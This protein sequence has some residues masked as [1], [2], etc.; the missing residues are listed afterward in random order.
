MT[1]TSIT[2]LT[3]FPAFPDLTTGKKNQNS[4]SESG[5]IKLLL[6]ERAVLHPSSQEVSHVPWEPQHTLLMEPQCVAF[7]H[8]C[9]VSEPSQSRGGCC[10]V[11]THAA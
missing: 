2:L 10:E 3:T 6:M 8:R 4:T 1:D 5:K 7:T 9:P 11:H